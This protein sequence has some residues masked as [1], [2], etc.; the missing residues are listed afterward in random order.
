MTLSPE[1]TC[2]VLPFRPG[3]FVG[4][5]DEV[6]RG[7]LALAILAVDT[8]EVR[9]LDFLLLGMLPYGRFDRR[10]DRRWRQTGAGSATIRA[11]TGAAATG[12]GFLSYR[13]AY[14]IGT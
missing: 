14:Q 9:V 10:F 13:L 7:R 4:E 8:E 5:H 6:E 1:I 12:A 11:G 3:E 2:D